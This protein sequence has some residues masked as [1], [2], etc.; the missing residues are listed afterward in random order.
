[1][2]AK[3]C[4][5]ALHRFVSHLQFIFILGIIT[6]FK[7]PD[8]ESVTVRMLIG[9]VLKLMILCHKFPRATKDFFRAMT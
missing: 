9:N 4:T 7:L 2:T 8:G 1:M 5:Y 6:L 3:D